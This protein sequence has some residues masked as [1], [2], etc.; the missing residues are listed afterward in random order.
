MKIVIQ[1]DL[2]VAVADVWDLLGERFADIGV[3]SDGVVKSQLDGPLAEG[4]LRTCELKP[5][6]AAS[7]TVQERVSKFDRQARALSYVIVSGLPGFMR[8][9]ENNWTMEPLSATRSRVTSVV[10][11]KMAWWMLPMSPVIRRQFS[12]L[13]SGFMTEIEANAGRMSASADQASSSAAPNPA[14]QMS[15]T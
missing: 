6:S 10:T 13:L 9:V 2:A 12:K 3:W 7:G 8:H 4:S 5:S 15:P 1:R 14:G 11:I